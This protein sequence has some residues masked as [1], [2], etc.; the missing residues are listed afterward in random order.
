LYKLNQQEEKK[1]Y[2]RD[3]KIDGMG[4]VIMVKKFAC[5]RNF[6]YNQD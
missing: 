1:R 5:I 3:K 2:D 6:G 4:L